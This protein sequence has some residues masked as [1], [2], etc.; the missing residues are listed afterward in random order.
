M[1]AV[2]PTKKAAILFLARGDYDDAVEYFESYC[3]M[4]IPDEEKENV[5]NL[6]ER[7]KKKQANDR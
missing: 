1:P 3:D 6:I 5:K 4:N 7:I 2:R